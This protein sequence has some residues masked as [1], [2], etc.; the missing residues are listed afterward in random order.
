[1]SDKHRHRVGLGHLIQTDEF[2]GLS[3]LADPEAVENLPAHRD[4]HPRCASLRGGDRHAEISRIA[5]DVLADKLRAVPG[6][7]SV[8]VNGS[9]KRELS[10]LLRSRKRLKGAALAAGLR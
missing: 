1:M 3:V 5:E 10:V 7:A 4:P 2:P 9:L 8:N 6:V